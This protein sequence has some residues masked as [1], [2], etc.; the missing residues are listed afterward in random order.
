M[1][2][3]MENL[4]TISNKEIYDLNEQDVLKFLIYKDVNNS[5]RTLVHHFQ[6]PILESFNLYE[7]ETPHSFRHG[8]TANALRK[9]LSLDETMYMAYMKNIQT[10][11]KYSRGLRVLFPNFKWADVGVGTVDNPVEEDTLMKKMMSWKAF[12]DSIIPL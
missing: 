5:G 10:A 3:Y 1:D 4:K 7:G 8:G 12:S 11:R 9:G 2:V 6:C